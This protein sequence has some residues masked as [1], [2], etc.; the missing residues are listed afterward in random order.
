MVLQLGFD[1]AS[2]S[3][4][5]RPDIGV[6]CSRGRDQTAKGCF[7]HGHSYGDDCRQVPL[8]DGY[9]PPGDAL[10]NAATTTVAEWTR[11]RIRTTRERGDGWQLPGQAKYPR[12]SGNAGQFTA[13]GFRARVPTEP[14][15]PHI[16]D[17]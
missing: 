3:L 4:N 2:C 12:L 10:P 9:A 1:E 8:K 6:D 5:A 14:G 7:G 17:R 13:S 16:L 11:G 15:Q